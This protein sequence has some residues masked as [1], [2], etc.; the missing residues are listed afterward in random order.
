MAETTPDTA[1]TG[2][3]NASTKEYLLERENDRLRD[4]LNALCWAVSD[5][6]RHHNDAELRRAYQFAYSALT[7]DQQ[8]AISE[9]AV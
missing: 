1:G 7:D 2:A 5:T 8:K 9:A 6:L 3:P 4:A